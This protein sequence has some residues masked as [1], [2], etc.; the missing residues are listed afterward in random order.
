[1]LYGVYL[2]YKKLAYDVNR[3]QE[4]IFRTIGITYFFIR[5]FLY[6]GLYLEKSFFVVISAFGLLYIGYELNNI[7]GITTG[8][9]TKLI[10]NTALF[11]NILTML[12][13]GLLQVSFKA[14]FGIPIFPKFIVNDLISLG[15][16]IFGFFGWIFN[17]LFF[18]IPGIPTAVNILFL[19]VK[20][21]SFI[22]L[23][24]IIRNFLIP[25]AQA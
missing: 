22:S 20:L 13:F 25:T 14:D 11:F 6:L 3:D 18:V 7:F 21:I 10:L 19:L 17:M 24:V 15:Q 2:L 12:F 8:D 16:A 23:I 9:E 4:S 1:M 5:I